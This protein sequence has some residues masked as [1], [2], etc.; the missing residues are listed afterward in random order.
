MP[1]AQLNMFS[2]ELECLVEYRTVLDLVNKVAVD[3]MEIRR[4]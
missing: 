4:H 3:V 2:R 1:A